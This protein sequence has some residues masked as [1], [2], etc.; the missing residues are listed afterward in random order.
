MTL[1]DAASYAAKTTR[2]NLPQYQ[3]PAVVTIF[4]LSFFYRLHSPLK[5]QS[6]QG[7]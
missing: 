4:F 1:K 3:L 5:G 2:N 6:I 7:G